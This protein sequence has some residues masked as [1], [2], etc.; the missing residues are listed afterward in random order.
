M[1]EDKNIKDINN[2]ANNGENNTD[3]PVNNDSDTPV[4]SDKRDKRLD[5]LRP[6]PINQ[7]T[8]EEQKRIC[9]MG[10]KK[11]G[12]VRRARKTASELLTKILTTNMTE[13]QIEEVLGGA[14]TLLNGDNTSYNVMLVKAL[15]LAVSGDTKALSF[16]RDT[17]GDMPTTKTEVKAEISDADKQLLDT[18]KNR[19]LG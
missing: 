2:T 6:I 12:E 14:K 13:E 16:I 4:N 3:G 1:A 8:L 15:Q 10:G 5:N 7:R 18:V 17:V 19:L 9:S 11:S